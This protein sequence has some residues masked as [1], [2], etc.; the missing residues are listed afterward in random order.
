MS[1]RVSKSAWFKGRII[2]FLNNSEVGRTIVDIATNLSISRPTVYKYID[3][4]EAEDR[5][6]T[7]QVGVYKLYFAKKKAEEKII[8]NL[9]L[10]F[11]STIQDMD[12]VDENIVQNVISQFKSIGRELI[13]R[14]EFPD[15]DLDV[16]LRKRRASVGDLEK[17]VEVVQIMLYYLMPLTETP[18]IEII[19]PFG[20]IKP[21]TLLLKLKDPGYIARNARLHYYLISRVI[22]EKLTILTRREIYFRISEEI[23][24]SD[25]DVFFELGYV[26]E[27]FH[28]FSIVKCS[29]ESITDK[30]LLDE[31]YNFYSSLV[32]VSK[33]PFQ[34]GGKLHYL[35]R[36][37]KNRDVEEVYELAVRTNKENM[38]IAI[39][40][41]RKYDGKLIRKWVD[42][43]EYKDSAFA[44]IDMRA[45]IGYLL[46]E[47]V[48][49]SN[50]AYQFGGVCTHWEPLPKGGYRIY[51][52]DRLDFDVLFTP[53]L[54]DERRREIY[55]QL[56]DAPDEFLKIR[57]EALL[58]RIKTIK[59]IR[60]K[61]EK[62]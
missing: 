53:M 14:M 57:K 6:T 37:R 35:F 43:E 1:D 34:K 31:I 24:F 61:V 28:D 50:A 12:L 44:I 36:F 18:K 52:K 58:R 20:I 5:I 59:E 13:A 25:E 62:K 27:Y 9:Y 60:R 39:E 56:T 7:Q 38:E 19:P 30:D 10:F 22:E 11:L 26:E 32:S 2:R 42:V 46:D 54:D 41:M 55:S 51:C 16:N 23:E 47:H 49:K 17:L 15:I 21:M 48:K 45:N 33:K 29:D 40:L 4:L 3:I 8:E